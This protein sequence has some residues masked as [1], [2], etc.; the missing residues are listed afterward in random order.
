MSIVR[1]VKNKKESLKQ[2]A[3]E[4]DAGILF[5]FKIQLLKTVFEALA[6]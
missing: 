2:D 5:Y 3:G 6:A 4:R 1:S